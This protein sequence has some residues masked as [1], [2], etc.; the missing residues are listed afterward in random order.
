MMRA[1][2]LTPSFGR[3]SD[4]PDRLA[5]DL[6]LTLERR[7]EGH[8]KS[9][10]DVVAAIGDAPAVIVGLDEISADVL[11]ACPNLRVV[12]KHGVG[13]DNIDLGAAAAAGVSVVNTPGANAGA[14]ADLTLG[15]ILM[16]ARRI[17]E[18]EDSLRAGRWEVFLGTELS[19][20]QLGILGFGRIGRAV[21]DRA[22]AF[23]MRICA[24]DPFV[25]AEVIEQAGARPA[26]LDTVVATSDVLSLH[27]PGGDGVLLGAAQIDA[28][29]RGAA[30]VNAAR[31]G[32][33]DEHAL[34]AALTTGR[35]AFAALDAFEVEPPPADHPL[36]GAPNLIAT[37]HVGAFSD[38]AN[39][40]MGTMV[41]EDVVRVLDGR[42]P[43]H[44]VRPAR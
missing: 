20:K 32:L 38:V 25:P 39:A 28:M 41:V 4:A 5:E 16:G 29:P 22:R 23:G 33:V 9:A 8:P 21:A 26:D 7:T 34:A 27:L 24:Y 35:L 19:G 14:V 1:V 3:H 2:V 40:T 13:V 10:A 37:P 36:L 12:A 31:G 18:A 6:G 15:L 43:A 44:P 42:E 17:R 30:L 11:A